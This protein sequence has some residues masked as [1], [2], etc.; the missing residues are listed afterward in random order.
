MWK[1]L[2][3]RLFLGLVG[4]IFVGLALSFLLR[5]SATENIKSSPISQDA[6]PKAPYKNPESTTENLHVASSSSQ[7]YTFNPL[8]LELKRERNLRVFVE[9]AKQSPEQGGIYL[10]QKA[11]NFCK[12]RS[13]RNYS[14]SNA[15]EVRNQNAV[16]KAYEQLKA[17]CADFTPDELASVESLTKSSGE[18]DVAL[19]SYKKIEKSVASGASVSDRV[20][21][22]RKMHNLGLISE[23]GRD[24]FATTVPSVGTLPPK[25]VWYFDGKLYEGA[26]SMVFQRAFSAW[27]R[28]V[29]DLS[30]T[31]SSEIPDLFMCVDKGI[32]SGDGLSLV[33]N[34]LPSDSPVRKQ[35]TDTYSKIKNSLQAGNFQAFEPPRKT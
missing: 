35:I 32:C 16:L 2:T 5:T 8:L 25:K 14:G 1:S 27:E 29:K 24:A 13:V 6:K 22:L 12:R 21:E 28:S 30:T 3:F 7:P 10:A 31:S 4:V 15:P 23:V 19:S 34:D 26:D 33:L 20:E 18:K 9:K 11:L 17:L